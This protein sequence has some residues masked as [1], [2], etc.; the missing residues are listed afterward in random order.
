MV[1]FESPVVPDFL[2]SGTMSPEKALHT[3]LKVTR[4]LFVLRQ[5]QRGRVRCEGGLWSRGGGTRSL[6]AP[7]PTHRSFHINRP[8]ECGQPFAVSLVCFHII[9]LICEPAF[10]PCVH[11]QPAAFIQAAKEFFKRMHGGSVAK[12]CR[13]LTF[14]VASSSHLKRSAAWS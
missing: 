3:F 13:Y 1:W 2:N 12:S 14:T 9:V 6:R 5:A 10:M 11:M 8:Y 7:T 4:F